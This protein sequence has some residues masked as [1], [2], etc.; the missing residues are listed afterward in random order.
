VAESAA[1][2]TAPD[3]L[4]V[5]LPWPDRILSPNARPHWRR[6]AGAVKLARSEAALSTLAAAG[7]IHAVRA[8]LA[9]DAP[10]PI[11]ITF[12]PPDARRRD[13][14]NMQASMKHALDGIAEALRVDDCRFVPTYA[15][16]APVAPGGVVVAIATPTMEAR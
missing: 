7:G 1:T 8:R 4:R 16:S 5:T 9:G 12:T 3:V 6:K 11:T 2:P 10:I 15:L 14:D 13:R